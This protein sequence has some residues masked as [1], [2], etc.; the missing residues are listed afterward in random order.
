MCYQVYIQQR[1]SK[2]P[3]LASLTLDKSKFAF[4]FTWLRLFPIYLYLKLHKNE[5]NTNFGSFKPRFERYRFTISAYSAKKITSQLILPS[6]NQL[7]TDNSQLIVLA[8]Q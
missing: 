8:A 1:F 7:F 5:N 4:K 6:L 3:M 2:I